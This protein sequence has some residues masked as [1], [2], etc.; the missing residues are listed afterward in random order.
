M[1]R[2]W[3]G[4]WGVVGVMNLSS[5]RMSHELYTFLGLSRFFALKHD[6]NCIVDNFY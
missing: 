3:E 2:K 5:K 1:L 6:L 4:V